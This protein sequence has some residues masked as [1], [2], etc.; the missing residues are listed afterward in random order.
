MGKKNMNEVI[1]LKSD[2]K[3]QSSGSLV[4]S[5]AALLEFGTTSVRTVFE[6]KAC[7]LLGVF[8]A[9]I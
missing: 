4:V 5:R 3:V 1:F 2:C 7:E 9:D 6:Q 8:V